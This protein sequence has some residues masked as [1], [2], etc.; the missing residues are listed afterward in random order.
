MIEG[1]IGRASYTRSIAK[2]KVE[3][4]EILGTDDFVRGS[5]SSA[6]LGAGAEFGLGHGFTVTPMMGI[7]F[8]HVRREYDYNNQASQFFF[9][10]LN[11][12]RDF[13][14]TSSEVITYAPSIKAE[15][16][17]DWEDGHS[18]AIH[19]RYVHLWNNQLWSKSSQLDVDSDSGLLQ[20]TAEGRIPLGIQLGEVPVGLHPFLVRTDLY[21]S[22][23]AALPFS[24]FHEVG[25][26]FTFGVRSLV[27]FISELR[28][29]TSYAFG[30][31][32]HGLRAGLGF[33]F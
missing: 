24:Y 10:L 23:R 4:T 13:L 1:A 25:F 6:S 20:T 18:L 27:S 17:H 14:N 16:E 3:G 15:F 8:S 33:E 9:E 21:G 31:D 22:A 32:F 11:I 29:G 28:L 12:D 19:S 26:D 30:D 2:I 7:A 5:T